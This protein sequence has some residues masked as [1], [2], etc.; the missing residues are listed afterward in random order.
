MAR[1][2]AAEHLPWLKQLPGCV[3]S[4]P[5]LERAIWRRL[6]VILLVGTAL[7]VALVTLAAWGSAEPV[8]RSDSRALPQWA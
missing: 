6:P 3:R 8:S 7:A 2:D 4:V 5:G 1:P